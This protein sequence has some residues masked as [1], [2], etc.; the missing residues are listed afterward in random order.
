MLVH[1]QGRPFVPQ[2]V[3]GSVGV[4][5]WC[6][7]FRGSWLLSLCLGLHACAWAGMAFVSAGGSDLQACRFTP[8]FGL[9]PLY[10]SKSCFRRVWLICFP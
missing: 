8:A 2:V 3:L 1:G 7:D 6:F 9:L 10:S 5:L 4:L